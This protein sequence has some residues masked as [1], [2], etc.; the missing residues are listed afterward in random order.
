MREC[1]RACCFRNEGHPALLRPHAHQLVGAPEQHGGS[2]ALVGDASDLDDAAFANLHLLHQICVCVHV[3]ARIF[4]HARVRACAFVHV[5]VL[6]EH[7]CIRVCRCKHLH[8]VCER[9]CMH[10]CRCTHITCKLDAA[11]CSH[12]HGLQA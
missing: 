6:H 3:H 10:V 2:L 11:Y 12:A 4:V 5:H 7:L 9:A 1:G 8:V